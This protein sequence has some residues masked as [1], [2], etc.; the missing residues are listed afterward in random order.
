MVEIINLAEQL[1][2]ADLTTEPVVIDFGTPEARA[3][4]V[5]GW[6]RDEKRAETGEAFVWSVG[7]RSVL[8]FH[9]G[10]ARELTIAGDC[11]PFRYPGAQAQQ[12]QV[13]LNDHPLSVLELEWG[14]QTIEITLPA[15]LQRI[16]DNELTLVYRAALAP[17]DVVPGSKD[18]RRLAVAWDRFEFLGPPARS[19]ESDPAGANGALTA[20]I[21]S[22]YDF[23]FEL[24][25]AS[26]LRYAGLELIGDGSAVVR[27]S[28]LEDLSD[29]TELA[30][31]Q[32]TVDRGSVALHNRGGPA[33]LR[34]ETLP[35]DAS[36]ARAV[37]LLA[38]GLFA[39]EAQV[40]AGPSAVEP[41][42]GPIRPGGPVERPNVIIYLVDALRAD[43]LGCYGHSGDL[44]PRLDE[45]AGEAVLFED[46]VAQSSWTKAAVASLFTGRWPV[47]H[48][49]N[50]PDDALP[51]DLPTLPEAFA[52]AG[53]R[54]AAVSANAYVHKPF[55]FGRG[56]DHF[57]FMPEG[58][59]DAA[60]VNE[61]A[62]RLINR[63]AADPFFLYLHTID[64]HA[65]YRAPKA[66]RQRFAAE[67]ADPS[68]G[69][70]ETVRGLVLG[71][72]EPSP[73][74]SR[75]LEAL[76]DAEVAANDAAFG[77]LLDLLKA[78]GLYDESV[79]LFIADHGEAFGEHGSFTHGIDLYP[80]VV[81]I[82]LVLRLPGGGLAGTRVAEPVQQTQ[83]MATLL[84]LAGIEG[85]AG[86]ATEGLFGRVSGSPPALTYLD[87]WGKHGAAAVTEHWKLIMPL[88]HEFGS[89]MELYDRRSDPGETRNL[90]HDRP[91][92]AGL[93]ASELR[94]RLATSASA[95]EVEID[96]ETRK[97]LEALGYVAGGD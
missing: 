78:R 34:I 84:E 62:F 72:V 90:I 47:E 92:V 36:P 94:R 63:L 73:G 20:P 57:V 64:P 82:P 91:V 88:S 10:W 79:I 11:R 18:E 44:S 9:L 12:I 17:A 52:D 19:S 29:E 68:V 59:N 42:T 54:T 67:V 85:A 45:F 95:P 41:A 43:R 6:S 32:P 87:Y 83:V 86:A 2:G 8:R 24:P 15:H 70:V 48:G 13:E 21:G 58:S 61:R 37:R 7:D 51:P 39:L 14:R 38:A 80:E 28:L 60:S 56:F 5:S 77:S 55:G 53:Y 26:E 49:A 30:V 22:T 40:A 50:G 71:T 3:S 69:E 46:A 97:N 27:V 93:L 1:P 35:V 16:G 31:L 74:L 23:F 65:P 66:L 81:G 96:A 75:D 4:L 76:Y 25:A 33:R 89:E